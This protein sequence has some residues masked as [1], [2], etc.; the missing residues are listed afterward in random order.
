MGTNLKGRTNAMMKGAIASQRTR[1]AQVTTVSVG[2]CSGTGR[3]KARM[4]IRGCG[5]ENS[6]ETRCEDAAALCISSVPMSAV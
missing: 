1:D 3:K 2:R 6:I 5:R 4:Y